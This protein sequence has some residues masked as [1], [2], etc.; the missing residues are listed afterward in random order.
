MNAHKPESWTAPQKEEIQSVIDQLEQPEGA[1][2]HGKNKKI[3]F[4]ANALGVTNQMVYNWLWGKHRM[5]WCTWYTLNQLEI[6]NES[7]N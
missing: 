5:R 3:T 4:V 6:K 7:K 2:D 1:H